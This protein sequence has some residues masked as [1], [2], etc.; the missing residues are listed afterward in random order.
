MM[1]GSWQLTSLSRCRRAARQTGLD[2]ILGGS[3]G[4]VGIG[5]GMGRYLVGAGADTHL[6]GRV[7]S[8][9]SRTGDGTGKENA[10]PKVDQS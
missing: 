6:R 2:V 7:D 1:G 9:S 4:V 5:A 3:G 10:M 8:S